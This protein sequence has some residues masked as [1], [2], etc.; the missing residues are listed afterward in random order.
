[1]L[2]IEKVRKLGVAI[3]T[4]GSYPT[5]IQSILDFDYLSGANKPSIKGII[6]SGRRF[7]RYFFGKREILI[8]VYS[9]VEAIPEEKVRTLTYFLNLSSGRRVLASSVE[10]INKLPALIGGVIF[11]ENVPEKHSIELREFARDKGVFV[12]GP[13]S[14][15]L[16]I[17]GKIKLGAIGG[18]DHK[19]IINAKLFDSGSVAVLSASGGMTNEIINVVTAAGKRISFSLSFGGDR[20]P[21]LKPRDAFEAA[22]EDSETKT[23]AYFGELGGIDEYDVIELIQTGKFT[24]KVIAYIAGTVAEVFPT[25]PQFG[26][27]KAMAA[28][29]KETARAKREALKA[30][31][32]QV[33]ESFSEF[34]NMIK[35]LP[36]ESSKDISISDKI[37]GMDDRRH[38]LIATSISKDDDGKVMLLGEDLLTFSK[39]H[40]FGYIVASMFLGKKISSSEL[41]D[42]V[43]FVLKLLVDHGPYVAGAVNTIVTSRAGRDLVSSLASGILTIGPRFGGAINQA[44][45]SFL[46]GVASGKSPSDFV[47]DFASRKVYISGIGHRKYRSDMPDPRVAEI[48]SYSEGLEAKFTNFAMEVEKITVAKKGNLI[49]NVDGAIA[50]VLL[51][52]LSE[53][54]GYS[55]E[56]LK[57]LVEI[58]FFNALFVASR[59]IGFISHF[60]D[61]KRLDEG[62]FRLEE[63]HV[64]DA[65]QE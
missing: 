12:I 62:I 28:T 6:A 27:A 63:E 54:E 30:A 38:A 25:S 49:L 46:E 36:D 21:I 33:A 39:N 53:K 51:D 4:I 26:H 31:G 34:V 1:M 11:A 59:S 56:E 10:I 17:P 43:N 29:E 23:V 2:K 35:D 65:T 24:K 40:S 60:L 44:A 42:F 7:E 52:I 41:E 18:V 19:Q 64:A 37:E 9:S 45:G 20:F 3:L 15:G 22:E 50:A 8:P 57:H 16:V 61:Q 14:V 5:I 58:E 55:S 48:I 13:A 32:V 47:E